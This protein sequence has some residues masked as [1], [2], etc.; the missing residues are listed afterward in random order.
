MK[1]L[2]IPILLFIG[3]IMVSVQAIDKV[4]ANHSDTAEQ[5]ELSDHAPPPPN[6]PTNVKDCFAQ[7]DAAQVSAADSSTLVINST[8]SAANCTE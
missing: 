2:L 8:N 6:M 7:T 4:L 5:A 1:L 3:V